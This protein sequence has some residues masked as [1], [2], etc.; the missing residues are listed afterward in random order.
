[1]LWAFME[2]VFFGLCMFLIS[3]DTDYLIDVWD[4][5]RFPKEKGEQC[6]PLAVTP[7]K[8]GSNSFR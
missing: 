6:E 3:K 8:G 4:M 1:M 2:F 5:C 7:P